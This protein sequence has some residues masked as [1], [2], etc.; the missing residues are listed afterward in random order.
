MKGIPQASCSWISCF[1]CSLG[2]SAQSAPAC[3]GSAQPLGKEELFKW[4]KCLRCSLRQKAYKQASWVRGR[5]AP[6]PH[7]PC[8]PQ[9]RWSSR[10]WE[11]LIWVYTDLTQQLLGAA[12]VNTS[13]GR[14]PLWP[15]DEAWPHADG[16][17]DPATLLWERLSQKWRK[18]WEAVMI[19]LFQCW[20]ISCTY[21]SA[22]VM[23][24]N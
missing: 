22:K 11:G 4:L 9:T 23:T 8:P 12:V 21:L 20:S 15:A 7:L 13:T 18:A 19:I 5:W 3:G 16:R 24:A 2:L 17:L 1:T 14:I 6:Q 10:E